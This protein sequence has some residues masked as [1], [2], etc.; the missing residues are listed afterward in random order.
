MIKLL[1]PFT[2][3]SLTLR[4]RTVVAPMCQYSAVDGLP[5]DWHFAHLARFALG[6]FGLVIAEATA[7]TAEGRITYGDTGLWSDA[8]VAPFR[9]I[10]E[11]LHSQGAAAGIQLAHAGRKASSLIPWRG[12]VPETEAEKPAIGYA[13]WQPVGPSAI[14]HTAGPSIYKVP[15]EL[16][17]AEL[18]DLTAAFVAA[19]RRA[20]QAGFD[21]VEIHA[22]HGYLLSQFLAPSANQRTD[23]Y[24]GSRDNRMRF[25]LE[26]TEAVRAVWP[27]EKPLFVRLSVTD[28]IEGGWSVEDSIVLSARLK[29]L[30]VDLIDCSSSGFETS[31]VKPAPHYQVPL[32]TAVRTGAEI[33][34]AA[35]GLIADPQAAE[36]ALQQGETDLI[37]L[38]RTA[39]DD[40]NWPLHAAGI[41]Q[42][43]EAAYADWPKQA[44]Y[45]VKARDRALK[46]GGYRA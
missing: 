42:S 28:G 5:D 16:T 14:R 37:A 34:V 23:A 4:N 10:V 24:G 38:A 36:A 1:S 33:P 3:R 6:G 25:P 44:G 11:F 15:H 7:V 18:A 2:L 40:P 13:D 43:G 20:D 31:V 30:G 29:A 17:L 8:Q 26:V 41:L 45:A 35:V 46:L 12:G 39:L 19:A 9:R 32:A 22:A 21:V 27:A